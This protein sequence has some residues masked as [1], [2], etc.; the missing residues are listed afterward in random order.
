MNIL[1]GLLYTLENEYNECL[2]SIHSQSTVK[3]EVYEVI[4]KPKNVAHDLLYTH[5]VNNSGQYDLLIKID[6]DMVI[7]DKRLFYKIVN[8]FKA[9]KYLDYLYISTYDHFTDVNYGG[10][11]VYRNTV[12]WNNNKDNYFTDR[13][14][15]NET[16]RES[17]KWKVPEETPLIHHCPNPNN[18]QA[19]HFGIHRAIK[20]FQF[21]KANKRSQYVH[22]TM[23][24][25][26]KRKYFITK[27][28]KYLLVLAGATYAVS[29]KL[30]DTA[31]NINDE[32]INKIYEEINRKNDDELYDY[33]VNNI[34]MRILKIFGKYSY[35]LIMYFKK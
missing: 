11:N 12:R 18:Y 26:V 14:H 19:F 7:E 28:R 8:E 33:A 23:F 20:A 1:V 6:A 31:I 27:D 10:V 13:V 17:K 9:N 3:Y 4:N 35:Y 22:W 24:S 2:R 21:G 25:K 15:R 30:T 32:K 29:H 34:Y 5:F 16:I